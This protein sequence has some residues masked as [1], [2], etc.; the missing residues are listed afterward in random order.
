[1]LCDFCFF[2]S[3]FGKLHLYFAARILKTIITPVPTNIDV[4]VPRYGRMIT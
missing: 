4:T 2:Y 1:M 3:G